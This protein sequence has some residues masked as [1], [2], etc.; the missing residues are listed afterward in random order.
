MEIYQKCQGTETGE[1]K[2][3]K[4]ERGR[5]VIAHRL[6]DDNRHFYDTCLMCT[7]HHPFCCGRAFL[8]SRIYHHPHT[9]FRSQK[10]RG[11]TTAALRTN[12]LIVKRIYRFAAQKMPSK[13]SKMSSNKCNLHKTNKIPKETV[14]ASAKLVVS[15][16]LVPFLSVFLCRSLL[17]CSRTACDHWLSQLNCS[18]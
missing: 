18:M 6:V 14:P 15:F 3:S 7:N 1:Q 8:R 11:C 13:Q 17:L 10:R 12:T 5:K 16:M 4:G 2:E 9:L